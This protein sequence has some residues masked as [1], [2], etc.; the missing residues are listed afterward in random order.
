MGK[1]VD[2]SARTVITAEPNIDLNE[3][4]VPWKIARNLTFP[5]IVTNF[6]KNMLQSYVDNGPDCSIGNT[7]AK[8]VF[9]KD[10]KQKDLRYTKELQLEIGDKVE[11]QLKDGD[12]VVFNRQPSLHKF[13]MMGHKIKV[14]PFDTFRMNLSATNPYNADFDKQ[15]L[16][17]FTSIR[18]I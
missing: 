16:I 3:L 10:G 6:N 2:F 8:F 18:L 1:R 12:I 17:G 4:G 9:T 15:I 11:R 14:M 7:G 5:E 13:S